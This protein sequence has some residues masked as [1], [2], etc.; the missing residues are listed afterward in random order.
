MKEAYVTLPPLSQYAQPCF[1]GDS[2]G[3]LQ[4][5]CG[6]PHV[7]GKIVCTQCKQNIYKDFPPL[8]LPIVCTEIFATATKKKNAMKL[9]ISAK[10]QASMRN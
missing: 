8:P 6:L 5:F 3:L 7:E 1:L 9:V 4:S 2:T 10:P